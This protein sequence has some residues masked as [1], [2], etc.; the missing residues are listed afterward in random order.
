VPYHSWLQ[1]LRQK[2]SL[3]PQE[4]SSRAPRHSRQSDFRNYLP[5]DSATLLNLPAWTQQTAAGL[6]IG[7][8][9]MAPEF[10]DAIESY[11]A[12]L[13]ETLSHVPQPI[14]PTAIAAVVNDTRRDRLYYG[15]S[16]FIATMPRIVCI[17]ILSRESRHCP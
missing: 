17:K 11:G 8:T 4:Y 5:Q 16:G 10:I 15:I 13:E 2:S 3:L 12:L 9:G 14:R 7:V 1:F 6:E